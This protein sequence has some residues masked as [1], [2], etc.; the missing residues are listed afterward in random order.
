MT[1]PLQCAIIGVSKLSGEQQ[2]AIS[3]LIMN[4]LEDE[5]KWDTAFAS[6][7]SHLVDLAV[8]AMAEY[9]SGQTEVLHPK[10]L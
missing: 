4:A 2:K 6:S 10:T 7:H 9:Q 1:D 5:A 3:T 8:E